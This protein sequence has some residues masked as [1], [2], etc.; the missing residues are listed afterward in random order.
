MH[1]CEN[2]DHFTKK[3]NREFSGRIIEDKRNKYDPGWS[4]QVGAKG[5]AGLHTH[6]RRTTSE[7]TRRLSTR[8]RRHIHRARTYWGDIF[9]IYP[10]VEGESI[11]KMAGEKRTQDQEETLLSETVIL[12]DIEGTTTSISFVKVTKTMAVRQNAPYGFSHFTGFPT[13][14]LTIPNDQNFPQGQPLADEFPNVI[15]ELLQALK[16]CE[17]SFRAYCVCV[18]SRHLLCRLKSSFRFPV[19]ETAGFMEGY[20]YHAFRIWNKWNV[21]RIVRSFLFRTL[22]FLHLFTRVNVFSLLFFFFFAKLLELLFH[23]NVASEN[24]LNTRL[25][26]SAYS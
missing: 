8:T 23:D 3:S 2:C 7:F 25:E 16:I 14:S 13:Y 24:N 15:V 19:R 21:V 6:R 22:T 18:F 12:V 17:L 1:G 5:E 26:N 20:M 10:A 9:V 11:V 4:A